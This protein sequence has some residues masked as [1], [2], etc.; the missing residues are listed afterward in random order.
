MDR[1]AL[2]K[3]LRG[4]SYDG[5]DRS[6]D[7]AISRLRKN[8]W[9]TPRNLT[10]LKPYA[11]RAICLHRTPGKPEKG[12]KQEYS[13]NNSRCIGIIIS[14]RRKLSIIC[15]VSYKISLVHIPSLYAISWGIFRLNKSI[16][17][18]FQC[19]STIYIQQCRRHHR[20]KIRHLKAHWAKNN[21]YNCFNHYLIFLKTKGIVESV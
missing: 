14:T 3:N 17:N 15:I 7:V 13:K 10:A 5:M 1:D 2:L 21:L 6:V 18:V 19:C 8:C 20:S 11:I 12:T 16:P 4:V 9:I